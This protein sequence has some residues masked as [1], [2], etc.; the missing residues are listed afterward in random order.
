[1]TKS[2]THLNW[3]ARA[4]FNKVIPIAANAPDIGW[5]LKPKNFNKMKNWTPLATE[6]QAK[7]TEI[8]AENER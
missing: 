3:K 8:W 2:G 1:V 4:K 7:L 5:T 6:S